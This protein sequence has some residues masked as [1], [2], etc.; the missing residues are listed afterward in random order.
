M[1]SYYFC[2]LIAHKVRK[3]DDRNDSNEYHLILCLIPLQK[4]NDLISE[5]SSH[6]SN[7][8]DNHNFSKGLHSWHANCCDAF[9]SVDEPTPKSCNRH[10]VVTNRSQNWHGLEQDITHKISPGLTY[11]VCARVGVSGTNL[12]GDAD[13]IATLKLEYQH[14]DTKFVFIGRCCI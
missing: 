8:I 6:T 11:K 2:N 3:L 9:L 14:S 12:Q 1:L 5:K 4:P 7:I 10:V 13:V